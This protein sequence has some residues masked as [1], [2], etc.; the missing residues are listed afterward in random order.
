MTT[1]VAA[2]VIAAVGMSD[3]ARAAPVDDLGRDANQALQQLTQAN[4]LAASLARKA[5]A[6]LIFPKI[7]KAGLVFGGAYGEGVLKHGSKIEGYYNSFTG[8]WGFQAGAES[9]GYVVFL[10]TGKAVDYLHS[11]HGWE[12]GVGPTVVIVDEGVAKNLSSTTLQDDAYAFIFD[13]KG[14]MAG[15]SVEGTKI[16]EIRNVPKGN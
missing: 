11:S 13:Q 2:A 6:V 9:Y 7:I 10:M 8:S 5:D 15:V 12:I 14:L 3:G 4:P 1:S 16:S